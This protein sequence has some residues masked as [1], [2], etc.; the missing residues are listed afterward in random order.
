MGE[1]G[2]NADLITD[3][4]TGVDHID[5]SPFYSQARES[6]LFH[7]NSLP[8]PTFL[9]SGAFTGAGNE[10]RITTNSAGDTVVQLDLPTEETNGGTGIADVEIIVHSST[11]VFQDFLF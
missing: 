3:F 9:G 2:S 7:D 10:L 4:Q 8:V 1:T 6:H 11:P 5:F